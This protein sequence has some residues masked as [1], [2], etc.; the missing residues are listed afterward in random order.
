LYKFNGS[1]CWN[2]SWLCPLGYGK[3]PSR[4]YSLPS[5]LIPRIYSFQ[6]FF[7]PGHIPF[8]SFLSR[9]YIAH[10]G[11]PAF[12]LFPTF[13]T[14]SYFFDTFL[15]FPTFSWKTP[16]IPTLKKKVCK[17]YKCDPFA[18]YICINIKRRC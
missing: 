11:L 5:F 16:T 18:S 2:P 4:T 7:H 10:A 12:L 1:I 13:P 9:L 3:I 15:L 8:C 17:K 6:S 14:F